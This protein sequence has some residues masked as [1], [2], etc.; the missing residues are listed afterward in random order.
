LR[1]AAS[2]P[3]TSPSVE[4]PPVVIV[5]SSSS[6]QVDV[7]FGF[8]LNEQL[9]ALSIQPSP[10]SQQPKETQSSLLTSPEAYTEPI[11]VSFSPEPR[12]ETKPDPELYPSSSTPLS[13]S[14]EA[15]ST[16]T[17]V[18]FASRYRERPELLNPPL[19]RRSY[20][21]V[22]FISQGRYRRVSICRWFF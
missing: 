3:P 15:A 14:P 8:E 5:G 4:T 13:S 22:D 21:I 6:T 9:L 20:E 18:D 16:P 7:T 19:S 2:L 10:P 11:M 12:S 17:A 1:R